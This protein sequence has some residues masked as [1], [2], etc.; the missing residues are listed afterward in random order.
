M[1]LCCIKESTG[2]KSA[3]ATTRAAILCAEELAA[4]VGK[5]HKLTALSIIAITSAAAHCSLHSHSCLG[6]AL[7]Q[8]ISKSA[9]TVW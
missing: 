2:P 1:S 9:W 5:H 4:A 3:V 8:Q 6:V 7:L